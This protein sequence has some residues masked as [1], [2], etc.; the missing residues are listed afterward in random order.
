MTR[1]KIDGATNL[2][3]KSG[4]PFSC[5]GPCE[6]DLDKI[7]LSKEEQEEL[8]SK[9]WIEPVAKDI[10]ATDAARKLAEENDIDLASVEGTGADGGITVGDVRALVGDE[11]EDNGG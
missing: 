7:G 1:V 4:R 2:R 6:V 5:V 3:L 10:K 8:L 9:H 11:S